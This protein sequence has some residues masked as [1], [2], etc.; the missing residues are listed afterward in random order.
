MRALRGFSLI[1]LMIVV[2]IIAII[3]SAGAPAFRT[4][5]ADAR[6]RTVAE[7]LA[8]DLR[9]AQAESVRRSRQVAFVLTNDTPT[10]PSPGSTARA[11]A[12]NWALYALPLLNSSEGANQITETTKEG[13]T[14]GFVRG[15]SQVN[16]S[17]TTVNSDD[18]APTCFNS[19]GRLAVSG[20][21]VENAGSAACFVATSG[22]PRHY[23]VQNSATDR[24]LWVQVYLGGQIRMCDPNK[25]LPEQP[26]GCCTD[27]C[28]SLTNTTYCVY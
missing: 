23:R 1:E 8:N 25:R 7:S 14:T 5:T 3:V 13:G 15:Y 22:A 24:P 4:W 20:A 27:R 26:E 6:V 17:D 12:R 19:L 18:A 9:A 16:N 28:C 21:T 2:V 10:I 11:S